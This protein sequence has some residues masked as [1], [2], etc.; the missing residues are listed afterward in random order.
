[1]KTKTKPKTNT[2]A[3]PWEKTG[4]GNI[5]AGT[6]YKGVH[7][8]VHVSGPG[9]KAAEMDAN[10]TLIVRAVNSHAAL[11][12]VL[13]QVELIVRVNAPIHNGSGMHDTICRAL[14]LAGEEV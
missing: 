7:K 12:E 11:V 13:K 3:L 9:L 10:A 8:C 14:K 5:C 6:H 4:G 1:M 2:S